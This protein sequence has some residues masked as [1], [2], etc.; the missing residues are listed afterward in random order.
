MASCFLLPALISNILALRPVL[1]T[2]PLPGFN[3]PTSHPSGHHSLTHLPHGLSGIW[4]SHPPQLHFLR[5]L[6]NQLTY[7]LKQP[8]VHTLTIKVWIPRRD[9][10]CGLCRGEVWSHP[11][12]TSVSSSEREEG[13]SSAPRPTSHRSA[14]T[15]HEV[16]LQRPLQ[17]IK[18]AQP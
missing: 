2:K 1:Q 3:G 11:L 5:T 12:C 18:A 17:A 9:E 13:D 7:F 8:C 16:V 4:V 15:S 6:F 10:H 14:V